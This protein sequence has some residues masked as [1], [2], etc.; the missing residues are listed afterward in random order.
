MAYRLGGDEFAVLFVHARPEGRER[1][2]GRVEHA[3]SLTR[4]AGFPEMGAS[5]GIAFCPHDGWTAT[6]L[7]QLADERMYEDKADR[8]LRR[9]ASAAST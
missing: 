8:R 3:A 1:L 9:G 5:A 6:Q 2:L 7:V 4:A